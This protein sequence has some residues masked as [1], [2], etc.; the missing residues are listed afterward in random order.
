MN[1]AVATA[2]ATLIGVSLARFYAPTPH[3]PS[4][5]PVN[6]LI[7]AG[8]VYDVEA[9]G[10]A[11]AVRGYTTHKLKVGEA[12]P[13]VDVDR[14]TALRRTVGHDAEIRVD[15]NGAW[16]VETATRVLSALE[17]LDIAYVEDPVADPDG[18]ADLAE[19]VTVPLAADQ[20]VRTPADL[21]RYGD[22]LR[23]VVVKPSA[24]GGPIAALDLAT[25]AVSRGLEVTVSSLLETAVGI[26]A[27]VHVAASIPGRLLPA[28]L[29]TSAAL[30]AD[31]AAA[32]P[33]E[34]GSIAVPTGPGLG[35]E[36]SEQRAL[37]LSQ[38]RP[39]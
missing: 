13:R 19:Q 29:A 6:A 27:W 39:G 26:Y 38:R 28:G 31:V 4:H 11:A 2:Q 7:D 10:K 9:A 24:V 22:A 36:V 30:E 15:A 32:P 25:A 12:S 37:E 18:F 23:V 8:G 14:A 34:Q 33:I 21:D 20:G 5:V 17:H 35:V 3:V 16:D 1:T